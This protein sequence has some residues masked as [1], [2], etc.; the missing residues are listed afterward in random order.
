MI[1]QTRHRHLG[2][3]FHIL[4]LGLNIIFK[5]IPEVYILPWL[6]QNL[7]DAYRVLFFFLP[8]SLGINLIISLCLLSCSSQLIK[9]W[10]HAILSIKLLIHPPTHIYDCCCFSV[11]QSVQLFETPWT[12][13]CQASLSF[14][15][16]WSLLKLMSI[17]SVM[18]SNHR[19]LCRHLLLKLM[20]VHI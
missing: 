15:I 13:A 6:T 18:L 12:V 7:P 5:I 19:I 11:T 4:K 2:L 3:T 16:S 8:N 14:S 10:P 20:S 17:E 1:K 9:S